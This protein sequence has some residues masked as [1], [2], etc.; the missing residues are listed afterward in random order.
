MF[1]RSLGRIRPLRRL[2]SNP[3]L[4]W[5]PLHDSHVVRQS[6][7]AVA[8]GHSS[9]AADPRMDSATT[10]DCPHLRLRP[11]ALGK[12][13]G[14]AVTYGGFAPGS[15]FDCCHPL[16]GPSYSPRSTDDG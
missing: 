13:A 12:L 9:R 15:T 8:A 2:N 1:R 10:G 6:V 5:W 11:A 4:R 7:V 14:P 3:M 16:I